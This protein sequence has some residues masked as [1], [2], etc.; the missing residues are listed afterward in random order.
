MLHG[1]IPGALD[2]IATD[3]LDAIKDDVD[4]VISFV[5]ELPELVPEILEEIVQD[6]EDVVSIVGEIFT[7]PKGA[8]TVIEGDAKTVFSDITNEAKS[9]WNE[10]TCFFKHCSASATMT[11]TA[12]P[13]ATL[14]SSCM[15]IQA[16]ATTT[17]F[18]SLSTSSSTMSVKAQTSAVSTPTPTPIQASRGSPITQASPTVV[19]QAPS[20]ASSTVQVGV[21]TAEA[22]GAQQTDSQP[23]GHASSH[24]LNIWLLLC[25]TLFV[26]LVA[27]YG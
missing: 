26:F 20:F 12:D 18:P 5:E 15:I 19:T 22:A 7:N 11:V 6:G 10:F 14:S 27:T 4:A 3:V 2:D 9:I 16:A 23:E 17:V 13:A 21:S 25:P 1:N 8:L 24:V